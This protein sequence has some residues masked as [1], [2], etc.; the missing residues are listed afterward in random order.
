MFLFWNKTQFYLDALP[1]NQELAQHVDWLCW[2]RDLQKIRRRHRLA[3]PPTDISRGEKRVKDYWRPEDSGR[4]PRGGP[5]AA[6]RASRSSFHRRRSAQR[7]SGSAA[8]SE[9]GRGCQFLGPRLRG[10]GVASAVGMLVRKDAGRFAVSGQGCGVCACV[11]VR[12][13]VCVCVSEWER[14]VLFRE[15]EEGG[16][17]TRRCWR[18]RRSWARDWEHHWS[19]RRAAQDLLGEPS[20]CE[21]G[22]CHRSCPEDATFAVCSKL[23]QGFS[24][25]FL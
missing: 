9:E 25:E 8:N 4:E 10:V 17:A 18:P 12:V 19:G 16:W 13:C 6:G 11:R 21:H 14:G 2:R 5:G 20:Q 3:P 1:D 15:R 23:E 7:S 24:W 22:V